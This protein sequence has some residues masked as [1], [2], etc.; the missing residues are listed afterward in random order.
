VSDHDWIRPGILAERRGLRDA[1]AVS[2]SA[3]YYTTGTSS[4]HP[5]ARKVRQT[6]DNSRKQD[7]LYRWDDDAKWRGRHI[8]QMAER[9]GWE[10]TFFVDL[11]EISRASVQ[12]I[13]REDRWIGQ[14]YQEP[15]A[16][17][18]EC[19]DPRSFD[20]PWFA[21]CDVVLDRL[22]CCSVHDTLQGAQAH[23]Q[24]AAFGCQGSC[25]SLVA[26]GSGE[27]PESGQR[28]KR[29]R[30]DAVGVGQ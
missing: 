2:Q 18:W 25:E 1:K 12:K 6:Y 17:L 30:L 19:D 26:Q 27:R 8:A 15:I 21:V 11:L 14:P 28:I 10:L 3:R 5:I 23:M 24:Q 29:R 4:T 20:L 13:I 22:V 9:G 16:R 7:Y